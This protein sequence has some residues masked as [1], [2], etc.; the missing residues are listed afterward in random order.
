MAADDPRPGSRD[1]P[2][3]VVPDDARDLVRDVAALERE[4]RALRRRE[5]WHRRLGRRRWLSPLLV[6]GVLA[7][8][9]VFAV[10]PVVLHPRFP[11]RLPAQPL[12]SPAVAPGQVGGLLPD[13]PVLT[14]GGPTTVRQLA[15][16]GVLVLLP[17]ACGCDAVIASVVDQ[18]LQVTRGVRLLT[19]GPED[20]RG[21]RASALRTG[22]A[23]GLV[24]GGVDQQGVLSRQLGAA[25]V[26][27]VLVAGDGVLLE[28]LRDVR[29]D[30]RLGA[31]LSRLQQQRS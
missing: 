26:T 1:S 24:L 20:P 18:A 11:E 17:A 2:R 13:G 31:P 19:A 14:P 16:P 3:F 21:A 23:R 30:R 29:A 12:A 27:V 28:V 7:V 5:R 8:V 4:L 6:G 9:A 25:G 10:L 15:R 22:P